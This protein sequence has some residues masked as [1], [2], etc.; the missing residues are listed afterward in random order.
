MLIILGFDP[1]KGRFAGTSIG[2]MIVDAFA[3]SHRATL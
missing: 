1:A 3:N 2:S